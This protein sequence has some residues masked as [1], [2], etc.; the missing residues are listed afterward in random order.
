MIK[1]FVPFLALV[2]AAQQSVYYQEHF[3]HIPSN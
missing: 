3:V 1:K 2:G